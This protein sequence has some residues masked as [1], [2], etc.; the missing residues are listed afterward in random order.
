MRFAKFQNLFTDLMLIVKSKLEITSLLVNF[1][2][3]VKVILLIIFI[4]N[5]L[6]FKHDKK[7]QN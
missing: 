6:G 7:T 5:L 2:K 4:I 1:I 3:F